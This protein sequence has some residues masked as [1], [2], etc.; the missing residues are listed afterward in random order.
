MSQYPILTNLETLG[1]GGIMQM[2][3]FVNYIYSGKQ[4]VQKYF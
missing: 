2:I 3:N 1:E 4:W